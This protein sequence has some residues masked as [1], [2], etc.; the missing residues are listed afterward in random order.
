M[1]IPKYKVGDVLENISTPYYTVKVTGH[2][3]SDY[4]LEV[5]TSGPGQNPPGYRVYNDQV[6][7]EKYYQLAGH[8]AG[9]TAKPTIAKPK[10][11][12]GDVLEN[13][14]SLGYTIKV[15]RVDATHYYLDVV[16]SGPSQNRPGY[17][18]DLFHKHIDQHY[19]LKGPSTIR[20]HVQNFTPPTFQK[21]DCTCPSLQ[22]IRTGCTCGY[23]KSQTKKWGVFA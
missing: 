10:F 15:T 14:T 3:S 6:L 9:A 7:V 11:S 13:I 4:I 2:A 5:I 19:R 22:L 12:V 16:T 1:S 8:A 17:H 20:I 23:A 21:P 18:Y